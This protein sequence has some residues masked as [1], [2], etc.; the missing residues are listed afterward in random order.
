VNHVSSAPE[1][2]QEDAAAHSQ[3]KEDDQAA[4]ETRERRRFFTKH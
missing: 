4:K 2:K 1:G 3:G